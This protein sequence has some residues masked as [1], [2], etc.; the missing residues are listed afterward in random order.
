MKE[1]CNKTGVKNYNSQKIMFI[2]E[3][4]SHLETE[5]LFLS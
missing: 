5:T 1:L 2:F 4:I 3:A